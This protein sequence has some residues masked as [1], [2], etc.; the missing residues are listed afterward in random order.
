MVSSFFPGGSAFKNPV[1]KTKRSLNQN[2][3]KD[4]NKLR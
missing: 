2:E 4:K 3:K 1:N